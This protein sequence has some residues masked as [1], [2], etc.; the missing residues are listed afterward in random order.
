MGAARWAGEGRD[1][2]LQGAKVAGRESGRAAPPFAACCC[3]CCCAGMRVLV[4]RARPAAPS[5]ML[6]APPRPLHTTRPSTFT[7]RAIWMPVVASLVPTCGSAAPGVRRLPS[8]PLQAGRHQG[9]VVVVVVVAGPGWC[10]QLGP[11]GPGHALQLELPTPSWMPRTMLPGTALLTRSISLVAHGSKQGAP[12]HHACRTRRERQQPAASMPY[13]ERQERP[14]LCDAPLA[15]P[16][17]VLWSQAA[18]SWRDPGCNAGCRVQE[19]PR[20]LRCNAGVSPK[21]VAFGDCLLGCRSLGSVH[22]SLAD[23]LNVVDY[24]CAARR[25]PRPKV[26]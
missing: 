26:H 7:C 22:C 4:Q 3:C 21:C 14:D 10:Q 12:A 13:C 23:R 18:P 24:N 6:P 25:S 1:G 15:S 19:R 16:S 11:R 5:R 2:A 9:V 17:H 20:V 8:A